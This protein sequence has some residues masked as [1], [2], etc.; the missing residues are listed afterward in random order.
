LRKKRK[1]ERRERWRE[2]GKEKGGKERET[3][4]NGLHISKKKRNFP[5]S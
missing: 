5:S 2:G 1:Q 4:T 3:E